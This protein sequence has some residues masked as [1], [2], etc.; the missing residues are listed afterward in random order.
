MAELTA[1]DKK[2]QEEYKKFLADQKRNRNK[3]AQ[4]PDAQRRRARD[5]IQS[6]MYYRRPDIQQSLTNAQEA[7]RA[8]KEAN[9]R[10]SNQLRNIMDRTA[11]PS[12]QNMTV[13]QLQ[14]LRREN[15]DEQFATLYRNNPNFDT[16]N[17]PAT[18]TR[19]REIWDRENQRR[20]D[21]KQRKINKDYEDQA[22]YLLAVPKGK[23]ASANPRSALKDPGFN[24]DTDAG[25]PQGQVFNFIDYDK[26]VDR[27]AQGER[28]RLN[29]EKLISLQGDFDERSSDEITQGMMGNVATK[30]S[31]KT[32]NRGEFDQR[33][34]AE[35]EEGLLSNLA[36]RRS[37]TMGMQGDLPDTTS[38]QYEQRIKSQVGLSEE[39]EKAQRAAMG[40]GTQSEINR[41]RALTAPE[42]EDGEFAEKNRME[43]LYQE[44]LKPT[45][46][47]AKLEEITINATD[48]AEQ[49]D[50]EGITDREERKAVKEQVG[51]YFR[52]TS[53]NQLINLDRLQAEMDT[54]QKRE[55]LFAT[56]QLLSGKSREK[57]M[58]NNNLVDEDDIPAPTKLDELEKTLKYNETVFKIA[59]IAKKTKD[60][61]K[62]EA[63]KLSEEQKA[64]VD[65]GKEYLKEGDVDNARAA[66]EA[67]GVKMPNFKVDSKKASEALIEL[68]SGTMDLGKYGVATEKGVEKFFDDYRRDKR[69]LLKGMSSFKYASV[70]GFTIEKKTKSIPYFKSAGVPLWEELQEMAGK[71]GPVDNFNFI[72]DSSLR[73]RLELAKPDKGFQNETEYISAVTDIVYDRQLDRLTDGFHSE[74][75]ELTEAGK[76][77]Q[78]LLTPGLKKGSDTGGEGARSVE[79]RNYQATASP[80]EATATAGSTGFLES[81]LPKNVA[82][83]NENVESRSDVYGNE[84]FFEDLGIGT[85]RGGGNPKR[86]R[87]R[88]LNVENIAEDSE[89]Q[90][91]ASGLQAAEL[92]QPISDMILNDPLNEQ[93]TFGDFTD[94][95]RGVENLQA[96]DRT[97]RFEGEF[98]PKIRQ[99]FFE[100]KKGE[101]KKP[102]LSNGKPVYHIGY[103]IRLPLNK[104]EVQ[105]LRSNGFKGNPN[106]FLKAPTRAHAKKLQGDKYSITENQ[107]EALMKHRYANHIRDLI[108]SN[109]EFAKENGKINQNKVINWSGLPRQVREVLFDMSYNIGP[110]FLTRKQDPFKNLRNSI[111][112]FQATPNS[113]EAVED[114]IDNIRD[115]KYYKEQV[116][117]RASANMQTLLDLIN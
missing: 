96:F 1:Y 19:A 79:S 34:S 41:Q 76:G 36:T 105:V 97:Q 15:E 61:D 112:R 87:A 31:R 86:A 37:R 52:D 109:Q 107:A 117:N 20:L 102:V 49:L 75:L 71:E 92:G 9:K 44:D 116:G 35:I 23:T 81:N 65:V 6:S 46:K 45:N 28:E 82:S 90:N 95:R 99:E 114:M 11:T 42:V 68:A 56:A 57:F 77:D 70:D 89:D 7:N 55:D 30:A 67:A 40:R 43:G 4:V 21:E 26:M 113:R 27:E 16:D 94:G 18:G 115:S 51:N 50:E 74:Y 14:A 100:K 53:T 22:D 93:F 73:R 98:T 12:I 83:K 13:E 24:P 64:M 60:L 39:I 108:K 106:E 85:N 59:E 101:R 2:R 66:F 104:K 78:P 47:K 54:I 32:N 63:K 33:S 38:K 91:T 5:V 10:E 111:L 80:L 3:P 110:K 48:I 88:G 58:I 103:G 72:Q 25:A 29:K 8:K 69:E 62:P 84:E 17:P